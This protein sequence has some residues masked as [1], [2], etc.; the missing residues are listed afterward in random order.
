VYTPHR[1]WKLEPTD[2][3]KIIMLPQDRKCLTIKP[4]HR[5][6]G[7]I[8]F[9]LDYVENQLKS[10][11]KILK[12]KFYLDENKGT[13]MDCRSYIIEDYHVRLDIRKT[14]FCTCTVGREFDY[15]RE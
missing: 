1:L 10:S 14:K 3:N 7:T 8:N 12:H 6:G 5:A 2:T 11:F 15:K 4:L 13:Q 9:P